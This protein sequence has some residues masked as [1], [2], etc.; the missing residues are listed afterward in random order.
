M[1]EGNDGGARGGGEEGKE[2]ER[3]KLKGRELLSVRCT[4]DNCFH[5]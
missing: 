2:E 4:L 1:T 3:K 5:V